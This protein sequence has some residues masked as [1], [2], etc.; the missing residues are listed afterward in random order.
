MGVHCSSYAS[1][2]T[3]SAVTPFAVGVGGG[4]AKVAPAG[5][6]VYAPERYMKFR[7]PPL[8]KKD[9]YTDLS[10]T[11]NGGNQNERDKNK[12]IPGYGGKK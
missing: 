2:L 1:E 4:R 10:V 11:N 12:I 3:H 9:I 7:T 8:K 6:F 5:E